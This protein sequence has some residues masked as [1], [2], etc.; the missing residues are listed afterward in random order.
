MDMQQVSMAIRELQNKFVN[1]EQWATK[2]DDI[3][4]DHAGHIDHQR[5]R[6]ESQARHGADV[7]TKMSTITSD[8]KEFARQ[9]VESDSTLKASIASVVEMIGNEVKKLEAHTKDAVLVVE[10]G[11]AEVDATMKRRTETLKAQGET[12]A[13]RVAKIEEV[14]NNMAGA[15]PQQ[16]QQ[17]PQQPRQHQ[18]PAPEGSDPFAHGS[19]PWS[20]GASGQAGRPE[21]FD[22]GGGGQGA[23]GQTGGG[24]TGATGEGGGFSGGGGFGGHT[25]GGGFDG[26]DG[27]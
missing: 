17:P 7:T 2:T 19:D 4:A 16:Q 18:Q 13:A 24:A 6:I 1:V 26:V 25:G 11:L 8:L 20:Q 22:I 21:H 5:S 15:G 23:G 27:P 3:I 10:S 12:V 14:I 9:A